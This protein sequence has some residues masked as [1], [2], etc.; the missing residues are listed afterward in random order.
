MITRNV[1][2]TEKERLSSKL[3]NQKTSSTIFVE[4]VLFLQHYGFGVTY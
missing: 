3:Y 2:V 1:F 4:L